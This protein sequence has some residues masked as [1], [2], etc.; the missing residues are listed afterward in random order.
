[1]TLGPYEFYNMMDALLSFLRANF[2]FNAF[3]MNWPF[4]RISNHSD[5][6]ALHHALDLGY[7]QKPF[8]CELYS[9]PKQ[10]AVHGVSNSL[11]E[12]WQAQWAPYFCVCRGTTGY[13]Y[14]M[15]QCTR[16]F[17]L[18][19]LL[20]RLVCHAWRPSLKSGPCLRWLPMDC[21]TSMQILLT[22]IAAR[23][24]ENTWRPVACFFL[25][26]ISLFLWLTVTASLEAGSFLH[27]RAKMLLIIVSHSRMYVRPLR[28]DLCNQSA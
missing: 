9:I 24:V 22:S 25:L 7:L 16:L 27:V 17:S 1:M 11:S 26:N 5:L 28:E 19:M 14:Q 23:A 20:L 2:P 8:F 6:A 21:S 18:L 15:G 3:Q 13:G 12:R 4:W 10:F